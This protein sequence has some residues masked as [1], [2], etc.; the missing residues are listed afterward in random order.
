LNTFAQKR[1][2]DTKS[3]AQNKEIHFFFCR[4]G[5]FSP[6]LM[7]KLRKVERKTKKFF[8]ILFFFRTFAAE[9][10]TLATM[11]AQEKACRT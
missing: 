1:Y 3:R 6:S 5:V 9:M 2:K 8:L 10:M 7:A 4:D 11:R